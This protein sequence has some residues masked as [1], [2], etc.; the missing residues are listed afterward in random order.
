M[1][2]SYLWNQ[3]IRSFGMFFRTIRA[4]FQRLVMGIY[5]RIRTL[6]NFSRHATRVATKGLQDAV[7]IA[8]KPTKREDYVETQR[9]FISKALILKLALLLVAVGL[10]AYF[11]VWPFILSHF[12]VA[13]FHV[14]DQRVES[15]TG[16][17]IVYS[18]KKKTV[19]MYAGRLE[20]G[21]L[22]GEGKEYDGAGQIAYE[23]Q[24]TDGRRTGNGTVYIGGIRI[25]EGQLDDGV[26]EGTGRK[27]SGGILEYEGQ[28]SGGLFEGRGNLYSDGVLVYSGQFS[29]GEYEGLGTLYEDGDRVYEGN[30]RDGVPSGSGAAYRDGVK[31]YE[32]QYEEGLPSGTGTAYDADGRPTYTG[33]WAAGRYDG[34][35]TAYPAQ[36]QKIEA[37]FSAGEPEGTVRWS[38]GG[39]PYYEGDWQDGMPEGYGVL[40]GPDGQA[41]YRG[42]LHAGTLDG[43]WLL[44]LGTDELREALGADLASSVK[45]DGQSFL[46]RSA[47]LGLT[48]RCSYRTENT[49]SA[50]RALFLCAPKDGDWVRLLP[51]MERVSADIWPE[52]AKVHKGTDTFDFLPAGIGI[53]NGSYAYRSAEVQ[54]GT[55]LVLS[56]QPRGEALAAVWISADADA[57]L[58]EGGQDGSGDAAKVESFLHALDGMEG[59]AGAGLDE[60]N[61]YLGGQDPAKALGAAE[62]AE[63]TALLLDVYVDY[64]LSSEQQKGCE[65]SLARIT[66]LLSEAEDAAAM[67]GGNADA[68]AVLEAEKRA[69]ENRIDACQISRKQGELEAQQI[70]TGTP[71]DYDLSQVLLLFDPAEL[72]LGE[73]TLTAV[74]WQSANGQ[75][76]DG[77]GTEFDIKTSLLALAD[78]WNNYNSVRGSFEA[79]ARTAQDAAGDFAMGKADKSAWYTALSEREE[80]QLSLYEALASFTK[81]ANALNRK[82]GGW[83]SRQYGWYEEEFSYAV[84]AEEEGPVPARPEETEGGEAAAADGE[85][86]ESAPDAGATD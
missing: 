75:Q 42:R 72:D 77:S 68:V 41:L 20:E 74:A 57:A 67:L 58:P 40:Y 56:A 71:G 54:N 12:L 38:R 27:F 43:E 55:A 63:Q 10:A 1:A 50:I 78:A 33:G 18:D 16:R 3:L 85:T 70:V 4:F 15:W 25:Y 65:G 48:A 29:E 8:Q 13:R 5:A 19:P 26:Y 45:E 36:G 37:T 60:D 69:L 2:L 59:T 49:E 76:A 52:G 64:W 9:L 84:P 22:Q 81:Q 35:G 86:A 46:L 11:L 30:F 32:G 7:S 82:T 44:G 14:E 47:A 80:L 21:V 83:L 23:G 79:A 51:G 31:R 62:N 66:S 17:V 34:Q 24:F 73:L 53:L 6:T 28:F 61:P 39:K